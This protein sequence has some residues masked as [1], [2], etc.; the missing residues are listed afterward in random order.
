MAKNK[1]VGTYDPAKGVKYDVF[2]D[3][4][5][6]YILFS[7]GEKRYIPRDREWRIELGKEGEMANIRAGLL[8]AQ[9][10]A[11]WAEWFA[12]WQN[13]IRHLQEFLGKEE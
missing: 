6:Y 5:G 2:K 13:I 9:G 4:G 3:Q 7:G 10:E 11:Q 8:K 12:E 1:R